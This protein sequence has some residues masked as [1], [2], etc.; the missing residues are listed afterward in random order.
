MVC[1]FNQTLGQLRF[2]VHEISAERENNYL[3]Y[4]TAM[5]MIATNSNTN[6]MI[7]ANPILDYS[8]K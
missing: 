5:I 1:I 7:R 8:F 2:L 4:L 3:K 6:K